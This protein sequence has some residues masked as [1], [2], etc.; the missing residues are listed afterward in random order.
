MPPS[1][2]S[3]MYMLPNQ[4]ATQRPWLSDLLEYTVPLGVQIIIILLTNSSRVQ[5]W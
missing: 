5:N 4:L 2:V 3:T 1:S